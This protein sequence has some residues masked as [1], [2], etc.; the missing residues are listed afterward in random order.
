MTLTSVPIG[1][2]CQK[3]FVSEV[4]HHIGESFKNFQVLF[5]VLD[6]VFRLKVKMLFYLSSIGVRNIPL[7]IFATLM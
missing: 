3:C 5:Y 4:G 7:F 1:G 2:I 6:S